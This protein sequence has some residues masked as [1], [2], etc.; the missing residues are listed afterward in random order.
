MDKIFLNN[1]SFYGYHGVLTEENK[2]GQKFFIDLELYL[3]LQSAGKNDDLDESVNYAVVYELVK[4]I[5]EQ[6]RYQLIEAL[7]E[8]IADQILAEFSKIKAVLVKV[9]KPE[10]P[11]PGIFDNVGVEIFREKNK[12]INLE[13]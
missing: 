1:L 6:E 8:R 3:D 11:I 4:E 10:A 2:L 9:K 7:A 5:C 12:S 13:P